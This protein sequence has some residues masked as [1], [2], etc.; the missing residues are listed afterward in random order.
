[1]RSSFWY[2]IVCKSIFSFGDVVAPPC[3]FTFWFD[4]LMN[5]NLRDFSIY[6][7][8]MKIKTYFRNFYWRIFT[9]ITLKDYFD[10]ETTH[11]H[12]FNPMT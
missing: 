11:F 7:V 9:I 6:Y 3:P 5:Y 12:D 1:M 10:G 2:F 4:L 8:L